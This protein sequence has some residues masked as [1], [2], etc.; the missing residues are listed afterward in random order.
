MIQFHKRA[1]CNGTLMNEYRST[2]D[3]FEKVCLRTITNDDT[4]KLTKT[5]DRIFVPESYCIV[6]SASPIKN[7][8]LIYHIDFRAF[9][10]LER[11][12]I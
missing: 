4:R 6:D 2:F 8:V 1:T 9:T 7:K 11:S 12:Y 5:H 10:K 3:Q